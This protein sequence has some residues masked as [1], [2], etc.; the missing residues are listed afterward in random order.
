MKDINFELVATKWIANKKHELYNIIGSV[1]LW[2]LWKLRNFVM[3]YNI[4]NKK[5][6]HG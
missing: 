4:I 3:L 6:E 1:V 2:C 5:P